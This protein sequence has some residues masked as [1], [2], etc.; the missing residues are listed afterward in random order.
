MKLVYSK[1][2][3]TAV[4]RQPLSGNARPMRVVEAFRRSGRPDAE[5]RFAPG[6]YKDAHSC[7]ATYAGALKRMRAENI[8][9]RM[10]N[11]R[12]YLLN[13][14]AG[15]CKNETRTKEGKAHELS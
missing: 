3:Y 1:I 10:K 14:K 11:G 4:L 15:L 13:T 5:I 6:E 9:V 12:V 2:R 7:R 8:R